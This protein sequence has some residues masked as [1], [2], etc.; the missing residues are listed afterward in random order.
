MVSFSTPIK[1]KQVA[2]AE[3]EN[4]GA[5]KA[6]YGYDSEYNEYLLFDAH[7]PIMMP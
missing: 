1:A 5:V 3:S 6:V 2:V 7:P 4:P